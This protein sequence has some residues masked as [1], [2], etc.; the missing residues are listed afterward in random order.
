MGRDVTSLHIDKKTSENPND[1]TQSAVRVAPKASPEKTGNA[2]LPDEVN[3]G[4]DVLAVKSTNGGLEEKIIKAEVHSSADKKM[5]SPANLESGPAENG[6]IKE[7]HANGTE[8]NGS[9]LKVLSKSSDLDSPKSGKKSHSTTNLMSRKQLYDEEDNWSLASSTATSVRT[10]ITVPVAPRFSCVN[11]LERRKEFYT[12][13]EEKHKALEK[14]KVEYEARIKEE[15]QAAIKQLRKNMVVKA[16][17]VPSFYREGPPPKVELKKLPVTR[18]K[19]PNLTRRK[20]CGDAVKSSPEDK[21]TIRGR[22]TRHSV[23]PGPFKEVKASPIIK[24]GSPITPKSKDRANGPK[25][26]KNQQPKKDASAENS[27][28]QV[29]NEQPE[30]DTSAENSLV[31]E[32]EN[33]DIPIVES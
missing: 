1:S 11:R 5:N 28:S 8:Y 29:K 26:V 15:E 2:Q 19:S 21:A 12:K 31:R 32:P 25:K 13:L 9:G 3:E 10:K 22:A 33:G 30:K 24:K 7:D 20:S 17:P 4:Q 23:G 6:T 16:N 27:P 14:E 18:A